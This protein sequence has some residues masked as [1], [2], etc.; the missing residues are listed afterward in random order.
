[1][2]AEVKIL[3]EGYTGE[4]SNGIEKTQPTVSLVCDGN[5]I[6]VVDPGTLESQQIL[7]EKLKDEGLQP[8]DINYVCITHSH[9]DHYRNVG[10]FPNAKVLEHFGIWDKNIVKDFKGDFSENI[11]VLETPGHDYTSIT[12]L[13]SAEYGKVAICGDVFWRENEPKIDIYAQDLKQLEE[14]RKLV[15]DMADF[16]IPGH[17]AMYKVISGSYAKTTLPVNILS[18]IKQK[19]TK[20]ELGVCRKCRKPFKKAE[21][22]CACRPYLCYHDC[23]CDDNCDLCNCSHKI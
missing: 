19:I 5:I 3:L 16:I 11:R 10:M 6:M 18:T 9:I 4:D 17:G 13:V 12:L 2:P 15:L 23:E 22:K 1:M 20:E 7:I 21:D 14:S 8:H